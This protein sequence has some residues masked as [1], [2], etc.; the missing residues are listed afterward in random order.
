MRHHQNSFGPPIVDLE[1][2]PLKIIR[3]RKFRCFL[4]SN[5]IILA[6]FTATRN[7]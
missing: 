1:A 6:Q 3:H 2:K 5:L 4:M 7:W